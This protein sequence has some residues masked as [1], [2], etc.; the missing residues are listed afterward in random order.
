VQ[1]AVERNG[2]FLPAGKGKARK[3]EFKR[4]VCE[5]SRISGYINCD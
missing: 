5:W 3:R 4:L 1:I 2:V